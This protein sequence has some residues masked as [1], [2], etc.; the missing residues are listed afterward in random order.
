MPSFADWLKASWGDFRR[1]WTVLLA[2]AGA[3]G[4]ATLAA[5]FLPF[6][7]AVLATLFGVGPAWA[8][9]GSASIVSICAVLWLSTWAQAALMRAA[10]TEETAR[11][12]LALAWGQAGAFGW[13]LSLALLAVVGG[14][15]LLIVPGMILS[16]LLFSAPFCQISGEAQGARALGLSWARVKP[17][18]GE[19]AL[20]LFA[21][22]ALT[23]APGWIPYAGWI[24]MLF[25][26]PFSFVAMARL[27]KDLRAAEPEAAAPGWM[28]GAIAGLTAV[29]LLG[30]VAASFVALKLVTAEVRDFNRPGGLASRVRPETAQA[31]LDAFSGQAT[32]DQKK[33]A[34]EDLLAELRTPAAPA[35][36][37][38]SERVVV[39]SAA[40][41]AR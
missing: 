33:K 28:G 41:G 13:V 17:H 20:R 16:V 3:G 8:V 35:S 19:V 6:L 34:Y 29:V 32:D 40:W 2:V 31:L 5:G 9:W 10:L 36:A 23:A 11:E 26:A 4:G 38:A 21:A 22:T 24:I 15:F 30:T 37:G 27:D 7:P 1:R 25:W 39:S 12:C 18:F 14:Y